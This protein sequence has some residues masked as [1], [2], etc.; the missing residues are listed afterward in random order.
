MGPITD[1]HKL[2]YQNNIMLAV[3]Q[4]RSRLDMGFSYQTGLSG[5]Q[6]TMVELIG[7]ASAVV[8]LGRKADTPDID[9]SIEPVWITPRQLAWGK[10]IEKEDAI[11]ALTDYQ[12]PFTQAG[13]AAMVRGKD[14][15]LSQA[16]F[17]SRKIGAD[18]TTVSAWA[19][20]T[21]TVGIGASST[22]DTTAT[23]MNV[24]KL[25]RGRRL[26]QSGQVITGDEELF[27]SGNAQQIEELFRDLT[28]ISHD[29]RNGKPLET[30]D[31]PQRIL[32]ITILPPNDG[33]AAFADYDGSTYTSALFC[34]S[35]VYWG[36][37]DPL[38]V[39]VPLRPDKMMR[40]HPQMEQW[41]GAARSEDIKVV[42]ILTKK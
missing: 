37:F 2:T 27:Y 24:R 15:I 25:L 35:G 7:S 8:D 33:S 42:K 1:A 30:P 38:T 14:T 22:D 36:E 16:M 4:K 34:K 11:K 6:S 17:G 5:R 12:G 28:F 10:L 40:P 18:G 39:N 23:G 26:M 41:L 20:Q 19:G 21:V 31:E 13:A 29:Y 32:N 3:Q 9:N